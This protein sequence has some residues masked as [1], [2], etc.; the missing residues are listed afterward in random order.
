[1]KFNTMKQSAMHRL[2]RIRLEAVR[3][4]ANLQNALISR[5]F[6]PIQVTM[7]ITLTLIKM[8]RYRSDFWEVMSE[9]LLELKREEELLEFPL[10]K[11]LI[12]EHSIWVCRLQTCSLAI[13]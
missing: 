8:V 13:D 10:E 12:V 6:P 7:T 1:M 3:R 4:L 5:K 2:T 9:E 11:F